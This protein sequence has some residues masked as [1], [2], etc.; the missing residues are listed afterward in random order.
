MRKHEGL[1]D[2][3]KVVFDGFLG[4][5]EVLYT[6]WL[7]YLIVEHGITL[8]MDDQVSARVHAHRKRM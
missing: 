4:R 8:R 1:T 3:N 5:H 6:L 2:D 7:E